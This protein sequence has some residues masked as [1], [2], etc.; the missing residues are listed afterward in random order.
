M[1]RFETWEYGKRRDFCRPWPVGNREWVLY[2]A[3]NPRR[4]SKAIGPRSEVFHGSVPTLYSSL[5]T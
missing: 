3:I 2:P 1:L 4:I 5:Q